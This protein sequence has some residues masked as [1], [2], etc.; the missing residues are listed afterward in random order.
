MRNRNSYAALALPALAM[1][2]PG[3]AHAQQACDSVG[4]L[5]ASA[6]YACTTAGNVTSSRGALGTFGV[7]SNRHLDLTVS[8]GDTVSST[9]GYALGANVGSMTV[10]NNGTIT[11]GTGVLNRS[12]N[13]NTT[14]QLT[15]TNNGTITTGGTASSHAAT[16]MATFGRS[17]ITNTASGTIADAFSNTAITVSGGT[18]T[19]NNYG[20]ISGLAAAVFLAG[21]TTTFNIYGGS[22]FTN[23]IDFNNKTGNTLNFH[24][25]SYTLGVK[26]FLS[27]SNTVNL[28][29][30]GTVLAF[31]GAD[32]AHGNGNL[33]VAVPAPTVNVPAVTNAS[34]A[35]V[36]SALQVAVTRNYV[37]PLQN[38]LPDPGPSSGSSV[39]GGAAGEGGPMALGMAGR[40]GQQDD[41]SPSGHAQAIDRYGN[42][43][44]AR[45]F[46][47]ARFQP[48]SDAVAG[49]INRTAG[50][51]FGYDRQLTRWRLGAYAGYGLSH[52]S[53]SDGSAKL[54]TDLY[55]G[56]LYARTVIAGLTVTANLAGGVLD[57]A[58]SRIVNNGAET[59]AAQYRGAFLAPDV[60]VATDLRLGHGFTLTPSLHGR[61]IGTFMQDY[62]ETGSSQNIAY[63]AATTTAFEERA[64]LKLG[65]GQRLPDGTLLNTYVQAGAVASQ[66]V[67]SGAV[68]AS[69]L[70]TE[71]SIQSAAAGTVTGLSLGAGADVKLTPQVSAYAGIDATEYSDATKAVAGRVGLRMA[72]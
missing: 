7:L 17:T 37:P 10:I 36:Q 6:T 51:L 1:L 5:A 24:T 29:V 38:T 9:N 57:N 66:R 3:I 70:G 67:G 49:N 13:V 15:L 40:R 61:Y 31:T 56:G 28:M 44:W 34:A 71:L 42:L 50:V 18:A 69:L 27:A 43:A 41:V 59:A 16:V 55:L 72:F 20:T 48:N 32:T 11:N 46:G 64:E 68:S 60:A 62:A 12:I 21:G 47:S 39:G 54:A 45:G 33:V 52:T 2:W 19:I 8:S 35:A 26:N 65:Y 30:P 25:G 22:V 63:Q 14:G 53:I 58:S 23:G 4:H